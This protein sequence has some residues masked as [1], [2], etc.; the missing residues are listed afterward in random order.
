MRKRSV[1]AAFA[2]ATVGLTVAS[3][4]VASAAKDN[5]SG[6]VDSGGAIKYFQTK[7]TSTQRVRNTNTTSV[8]LGLGLIGCNN[9][10]T[11][12][13]DTQVSPNGSVLWGDNTANVCF[14]QAI[15]RWYAAD[16]NGWLPGNGVTDVTGIIYY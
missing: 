3:G 1:A 12:A 13:G 9:I 16:T 8:T 4:G 11:I 15:H 14:R 6:T 2:A 5:W 7:R 10:T